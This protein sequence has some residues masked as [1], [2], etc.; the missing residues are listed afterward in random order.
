M[1][2]TT[3]LFTFFSLM[4]LVSSCNKFNAEEQALWDQVMKLHDDSMLNHGVMM[5][6]TSQIRKKL[7]SGEIQPNMV[8]A[9]KPSLE[10]I[11]AADEAMMSWMSDLKGPIKL[12]GKSHE[13]IMTYLQGEKVKIEKID[14]DIIEQ[15]TISRNILNVLEPQTPPAVTQ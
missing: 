1:R 12:S 11:D 3:L 15:L 4:V 14:K 2:L 13:E 7:K 5:K 9:F 8:D 6:N 10:K